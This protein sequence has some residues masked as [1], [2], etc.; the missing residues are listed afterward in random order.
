M[1]VSEQIKKFN[2]IIE[3]NYY[4]RLLERVRTG[5]NFMIIEF[6]D[7]SKNDPDLA[8]ELLENPEEIIKAFELAIEQFDLPSEV[9]GF[10]IRIKNLPDSQKVLIRNVRSKHIGKLL[11]IEG[12]VR[13]KSDVRPQVTSAKFECPSCGNVISVLQLDQKFKE[14]SRCGCGRKGKF[15]LLNKELIDAQGLV[16][17]EAPENLE[18]GEQPKRLNVFLKDDLVSPISEKRTNPGSKIIVVGRVKEIPITLHSGSQSVRYD[19]LIEAN[20]VDSVEEDYY[21]ILINDDEKEKIKELAADRRIYEKIVNSVAPSIYG[22]DKVKEAI[23]LQLVGGVKKVRADGVITRGDMHVLLIGDPG[24][25][26]CTAGNTKIMLE[27]GDITTIKSFYDEN[28]PFNC[29]GTRG[30]IK[31]FS[32]NENGLNHTSRPVRF[33][34]RPAPEKMLKI[35]TATGNKLLVTEDHPLFTTKNGFIFAK[36]V[37]DYET[38]QYIATP[39]K[40]NIEG[41][42]QR[43]PT[44]ITLSKANNRIKYDIKKLF[45]QDFA[46][47]FGYLVGDGYTRFRKTSG[48]ISFTNNNQEL[49]NDFVNLIYNIFKLKVS[50]R[51]K[52]NSNSYEYYISSIELVRILEKIDPNIIKKSED[53][54]INKLLTKSP[55]HIIKEFLKSLFD[56]EGHIR[57]DRREIEFN[58]KSQELIFD[59]KY[60]L[61]RFGIISQVSSGLK[62]ASNT[63]NKTKRRYYGLRISGEDLIKFYKKIGFVSKEKQEKLKFWINNSIKLNTNINIVPNIKSLLRTLRKKYKLSQSSFPILR[64][65]YQDYERGDRYPSHTKLKKIA[66][67]YNGFNTKDPL[68]DILKQ[69]ANADIFWDKIKTI[70]R[71]DSTED[72]VY[73]LEIEKVHNFIA[74][75]VV[76]HNSQLLKRAA[77]VA[78][79]ARYVSGKGASGAGLTAAVVKDEFLKGWSLEAGALVLANKGLC[80]TTADSEFIMSNGKT[81]SFKDLFKHEKQNIIHPKFKILALDHEDLKIKPFRIKQAIRIKNNKKIYRLTTRTGRQLNLTEDNEVL[82]CKN[83]NIKWFETHKIKIGDYIAVPKNYSSITP[84]KKKIYNTDFA[85]VAGLIASDGHI[86]FNNKNAM[87]TFY[88]SEKQLVNIYK[89]KLNKLKITHDSKTCKKGQKFVIDNKEYISKKTNF[90]VYNRRKKFAKELID[91]GVPEG[92]KS[93]VNKINPKIICYDKDMIANFLRGV[94]DGD[95]CIRSNPYEINLTTGIE[96]NARLF[97]KLLL[98]TGIISSVKRSTGSWHCNVRGTK[99]CLKFFEVIGTNHW[100][101]FDRLNKISSR[102]IKDRI[103]ILPNHQEYFK[104]IKTN[105]RWKL[106]KDHFKYIWNYSKKG[107]C[108]SKDKLKKLNILIQD[109]HL[110]KHIESDILWDKVTKIEKVKSEYVYDFTMQGTDNF[111]ANDIIMHNCID[112]MDKM[113][114]EDRSAMHEALE[115]Q[116]I[117]ISKANIQATLR[118]ETTVLAAANP[119]FGRFDPYD[120]LAKQIDLPPALISRFD[121]IFPIKDM[122]DKDKDEKLAKHVLT[123]HQ[124]PETQNPDIDTRLLKKFIAYARQTMRPVLTDSA[125]DEI[126]KFYVEMRNSVSDESGSKSVPITARQLEAL[127][128][129]AEANAKIRLSPKVTKKDA[130]RAIEILNYCLSQVGID[131]ET[132]KIDIDRISSGITSS[133]RNKIFAIKEIIIELENKLGKTIP[134]EDITKEGADKGIS[135]SD[136]DEVIEKLKR[137]GDLFEPRRGFV[138]RI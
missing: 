61:L 66:Q 45:D 85:Y 35:T 5:K 58:S 48:I 40:I 137:S 80:C 79:K 90:A 29:I 123:L 18:G 75:G 94:F 132:G 31:I 110:K 122:P 113:S 98:R 138:S 106:G 96:D 14:P 70:E 131:P 130:K 99:N 12:I 133:Q 102:E 108:P 124:D 77:I 8:N 1:D 46:R 134:I 84:I 51:K 55:N 107:V 120:I 54:R 33:W 16:L 24:A 49:L 103:D 28:S 83:S 19:L 39:S 41:V 91:F 78:P 43:I 104:K 129:M 53:M 21:D 89:D 136:I 112:E 62:F 69:I 52:Q 72:Y 6:S 42:I 56:C 25:G 65:T 32:I 17:E 15:I 11:M 118:A 127:V 71:V 126:K 121:L 26:K 37:K 44:K 38:G 22:Y 10:K 76:V 63:Q 9:K 95:G 60:I 128:R 97:Q 101:K 114:V 116:T 115:Q 7:I 3:S 27:N 50:K 68:I 73:D 13:Q 81:K 64:S 109:L 2:E 117:T 88:N 4:D 105:F 135:E 67:R 30:A 20:S 100:K 125:I 36:K 82:T 57:E 86:K 59:I 34:R 119:K 23:I 93:K 111:I 47:L 87:T 92:N 74:N